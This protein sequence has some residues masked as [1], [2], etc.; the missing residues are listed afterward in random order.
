MTGLRRLTLILGLL[1]S[2]SICLGVKTPDEEYE[3][4]AEEYIR[5]YLSARPLLG[6]SLG[7]H[8]YD[9][10]I[11]D[12]SRLALD[13]ELS[14]LHRFDDRL[15]KFD[16]DKLSPRQ[17]IDLRILQAAIRAELFERQDL[18]AFERN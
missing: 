14:R 6:T 1:V 13:A 7:L 17:S 9:G 16:L 15:R 5:G 11:G 2:I 3:S 8:E 4:V 10:K 12:Y 18:A